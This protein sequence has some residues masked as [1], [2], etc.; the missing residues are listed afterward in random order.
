MSYH[1]PRMATRVDDNLLHKIAL[2]RKPLQSFSGIVLACSRL[3]EE[4][5]QAF[6]QTLEK[7][8]GESS[9]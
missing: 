1:H 2:L 5:R 4:C 6:L 8:A 9:R 3:D 7:N